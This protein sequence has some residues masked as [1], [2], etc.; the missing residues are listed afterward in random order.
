AL[1]ND[2]VFAYFQPCFDSQT[3]QQVGAEALLRVQINGD[4]IGPFAFLNL[5]KQTKLNPTITRMML[6]QSQRLLKQ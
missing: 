1:E 5:I 3:S 2:L 6:A 4:I